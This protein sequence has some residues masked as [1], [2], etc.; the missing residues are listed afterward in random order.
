MSLLRSQELGDESNAV[1]MAVV[2]DR[3]LPRRK[4]LS[5]TEG[6]TENVESTLKGRLFSLG[7]LVL[8]L[9]LIY[10]SF[11]LFLMML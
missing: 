7:N 9:K 1:V 8:T 3:T 6:K 2:D 10:H 11:C 4:L 5:R